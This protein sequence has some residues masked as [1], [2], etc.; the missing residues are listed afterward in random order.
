MP[1]TADV[2]KKVGADGR[3][4]FTNQRSGAGYRLV[5]RTPKKGTVAYQKFVQNRD[6][7]TPL[8][9]A[10]ASR[11]EVDPALVLAVVHAESFYD[12]NAVSKVGAT[13]L[14]Q[15]MP[16][17]AR[18]YGVTD[19]RDPSQNVQGGAQYLR[20]LLEMFNFDLRLALA[21]YNAGEQSVMKYGMVIPPYPETQKYVRKVIQYYQEY[22]DGRLN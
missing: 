18:K 11:Y 2:Y 14:M 8:I 12:P 16:D 21:A 5:M 3:I 10:E 1:V 13:G 9:R 6:K 19:R 17:T 22:L 20:D 4:Y 15:L 7:L